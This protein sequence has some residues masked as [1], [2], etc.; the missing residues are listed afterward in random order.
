MFLDLHE[1]IETP[2]GQVSFQC[3]LDRQ[4]LDFPALAGFHGAVAAAGMVKNTAGILE[5]SATVE[6][7]MTVRCDRCSAEFSQRLSVPVTATLKA[8]P[9]REEDDYEELFPLE[10]DG[11]DVSDLLETCFILNTE[12]KFLCRPEC[13]G[14]CPTCGRN[15]NDGPCGCGKEPDPRM[16]VLG[17]LLDD[18]Q[19][20]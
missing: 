7:D 2:G 10:G 18:I 8:D 1:I 6:A 9:E 20:V 13:K 17:Q 16:A 5:L 19:E 3:E 14:L 12:Q 15:L 4:R 11:L